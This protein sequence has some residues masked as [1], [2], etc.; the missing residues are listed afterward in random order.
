MNIS[1]K[2]NFDHR[3]NNLEIW[4]KAGQIVLKTFLSLNM[5]KI[6]HIFHLE[7]NN[8]GE[9]ENAINQHFL[10]FP[11]LFFQIFFSQWHKRSRYFGERMLKK[12]TKQCTS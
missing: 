6:A 9:G 11:L 12:E 2:W 8:L 1:Q 7:A 4:A 10:F 3:E 5:G